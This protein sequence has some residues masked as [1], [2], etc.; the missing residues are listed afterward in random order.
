MTVQTISF[1]IT[2]QFTTRRVSHRMRAL[3]PT[4]QRR[5][6]AGMGTEAGAELD[7]WLRQGGLVVASSDRAARAIQA[8]FH[9]RRRADG[10][11][12]W[13]APNI[14]DWTT[15]ARTAWDERNLAGRLLLNPAQELAL[16]SEI[17]HSEQHLPTALK[18][19]VRRLASLAM[20]ARDLLCS[21]APHYL[22]TSSRANWDQDAGAFSQWFADFDEQCTRNGHI[23]LS[24]LPLELLSLLQ[25]DSSSRPPLRIAGFD[26]VLPTQ[27]RL[28]DAWGS[29]Q[30]LQPEGPAAQSSFHSARDHQTELESCANW[31]HQQLAANPDQRLLIITQ[32]L[33]Q[34]RGEIERVF[35][36]FSDPSVAP[37]FE[38]SLGI[39]LSQV[40]L[41]RSALFLLRWLSDTLDENALDWLFA[42]GLAAATEES[43][44]LQSCMRTLRRFDQQ[45][46]QWPLE[47]FLNQGGIAN[48]VPHQWKCRMIAAQRSLKESASLQSPIEWADKVPY[49]LETIGWSGTQSQMSVEFQA[50]R[51]WQQALDTAGSLGFNGRPISWHEFLAELGH[52]ADDILFAPQSAD[53]PIQIAGPAESAGLAADALWFLGAD[54]ESW[55]AVASMHPFLPPYVQRESAMP[56]SSHQVDWQ[57]ASAITQRLLAS[58]SEAHFSFAL[59]K[60]D[61]ESRPSRLIARLAGSP[62]PMQEDLL[63]PSHEPPIAIPIADSSR[64]PFTAAHL[65]GGAAVLSSQSQCPFKAFAT[66]RLAAESWDTAEAGLSA[67][68]RGKI[69]H[70]V[71]HSVWS[72]RRPGIKTRDDLIAI[73]D[74]AGFVR[75]H[76]K[77]GLQSALQPGISEQMPP[78]Y[79]ELEETRLV[80]L[81]TEW[82]EFERTRETFTVEQTE[83]KRMVTMAGLSMNLRLD[84]VDRLVDGSALVIDYKTGNV[85]PRSWD[86][87]RPDDLQLPLYKVFGLDPVQPSLF[88]SYGGPAS[89]GL[90]FAKIRAG[91]T[92]FAGRVVDARKTIDPGLSGNSA[93]VRRK[94]TG[95][96][97]SE[98]KKYIERLADEFIHG[99]AD[100][101]PRD[102][103]TTCERC[104]LQSVCR[105][106]EP[107]N[108]ARVEGE[109]GTEGEDA[110]EE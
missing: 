29:W 33:S 25:E 8:E 1:R 47:G 87:P 55:P 54:E 80:R 85:D 46:L 60:D 96:D 12:A 38:F 86:L 102:Y 71:L 13:P 62:L 61:V 91:D 49:L 106:Q 42:S 81:V 20:E 109:E 84:R 22:R 44:A 19:S 27:R 32:N 64:I 53:A 43:A 45:R 105:I 72:G 74:L 66:A 5:I 108:R 83:A 10:L 11:S 65:R 98:W 63:P 94:L 99:R 3:R 103:P 77:A 35:L 67:R 41:A 17:I 48:A 28:F 58:A 92:C 104:G 34:R 26:R 78:I 75:T 39:P 31:C 52:A 56:H 69:L 70:A 9:R 24:R 73:N 68:Q 89:G 97:E 76:V 51:R 59:H 110:A 79:L 37:P 36:R 6:T 40:P 30:L 90:V 15:F 100:V 88:D 101:D 4:V 57:F 107:E 18:A 7:A 14:L 95:L 50:L 16:W 23:S 2:P 93:L 82:L 21:Y